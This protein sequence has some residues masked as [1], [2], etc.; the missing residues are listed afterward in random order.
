M[1][2]PHIFIFHPYVQI[3]VGGRFL[4]M[5]KKRIDLDKGRIDLDQAGVNHVDLGHR[6]IDYSIS[7][8]LR[9]LP[10]CCT[11]FF[12]NEPVYKQLRL[13]TLVSRMPC[14]R[15]PLLYS[16]QSIPLHC[17]SPSPDV[18]PSLHEQ[19]Q[20]P[21][22]LRQIVCGPQ[23]SGSFLHSSVSAKQERVFKELSDA[24]YL[25]NRKQKQNRFIG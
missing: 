14:P 17:S 18:N 16:P 1:F 7:W 20:E 3:A 15:S 21:G 22:T 9:V 5:G 12:K 19:S 4:F 6:K 13:R 24:P 11:F 2:Q 23:I 10:Y 8:N 25:A